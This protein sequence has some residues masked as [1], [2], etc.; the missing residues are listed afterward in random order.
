MGFFA[1]GR[2]EEIEEQEARELDGQ[3]ATRTSASRAYVKF[4]HIF[5][6]CIKYLLLAMVIAVYALFFYRI[7]TSKPP[8]DMRNWSWTHTAAAVYNQNPDGF[9]VYSQSQEQDISEFKTQEGYRFVF[10][11]SYILYSPTSNQFQVTARYNESM[12]DPL[13]A[14]FGL[15]ELPKE[16]FTYA[17]R[18]GDGNLYY[19][20]DYATATR[21]VNHFR[22]L[23]FS[24]VPMASV[25]EL[26]LLVCYSGQVNFQNPIFELNVYRSAMISEQEDV[27]EPQLPQIGVQLA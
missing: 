9:L 22:R 7:Q 16:W 1:D 21:N 10:Q 4:T 15:A 26:T 11:T 14:Q 13:A 8:S 18:D 2:D 6:K 24:G 25:D 20:S 23:I 3:F 19:V 27:D 12:K 17:L 5:P